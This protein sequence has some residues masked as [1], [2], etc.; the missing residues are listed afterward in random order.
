MRANTCSQDSAYTMSSC[1]GSQQI[2]MSTASRLPR[3]KPAAVA[4]V[5][6]L[7]LPSTAISH[8]APPLEL[9]GPSHLAGTST[10][11]SS[12][13]AC[14][15]AIFVHTCGRFEESRAKVIEAT[16]ARDRTEVTFITD[17]ATST[18]RRHENLGP[19]LTLDSAHLSYHPETVRKMLALFLRKHPR[20]QWLMLI[21]DDS[22]LFV[23]RL[24]SFLSFFDASDRY[25]LADFV[26]WQ[27]GEWNARKDYSRWASGGPGIVFS[28]AAVEEYV[29]L[30]A[31]HG[32][33]TPLQNHDVWLALLYN[34]SDGAIK[35]VHCPGFHQYGF[36]KLLPP[37]AV[38]ANMQ[39]L[40][41]RHGASGGMPTRLPPAEAKASALLISVHFQR[42]MRA[43]QAFHAL[44][45]TSA[46]APAELPAASAP[47]GAACAESGE[48]P[49]ED[50]PQE[51]NRLVDTARLLRSAAAVCGSSG[52][53]GRVRV[54]DIGGDNFG[55][56]AAQHGWEYVTIDLA[57]P[58]QM[59]TGGH[60][61]TMLTYDGRTLPFAPNSFDIVILSFVLHHAA[62]N[63]L[64][65]LKQVRAIATGYVLVGEDLASQQHP[66][67][68]H[69][70]NFAHHPG[71]LFR[72][73]A[74]WRALFGLHG[75]RLEGAYAIRNAHDLYVELPLEE[76]NAH[77][78][79]I[80][81]L[82]RSA[83]S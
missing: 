17:S 60:R 56:L 7:L 9:S 30:I 3:W 66:L 49:T 40:I 44:V 5:V 53:S 69:R 82:L 62:E 28:R 73:D 36:E 76:Y 80:L 52:A 18:L 68:W 20:A 67:A 4:L 39:A 14:K 47:A 77:V 72:S 35:R 27:F 42:D 51:T 74:E 83:P 25:V 26:H 54:L 13:P 41:A 58:Q 70:R 33:T 2:L 64:P 31:A 19:Y 43:L 8:L 24:L 61:E 55:A 21:D 57:T 12:T 46:A 38:D 78:Y 1:S 59:G 65:L 32:A 29:R 81:Y 10:P 50:L 75:L 6:A 22:Y 79:R 16:W 37:N 45:P 34:A 71:G 48:P 63:T 11:S 23:E 15:L